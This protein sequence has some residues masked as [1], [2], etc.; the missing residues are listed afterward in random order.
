MVT[1]GAGKII[2]P[3]GSLLHPHPQ[4]GFLFVPAV[5]QIRMAMA[6]AGRTMQRARSPQILAR[7]LHLPWLLRWRHFRFAAAARPTLMVM[8]GV[9]KMVAVVVFRQGRPPLRVLIRLAT[10]QP[11]RLASRILMVT[12]GPLKTVAV[13]VFRQGRPL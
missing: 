1:A 13:V 10:L 6:L 12:D 9:L 3:V 4:P 7:L 5:S 2:K 11:A 8:A